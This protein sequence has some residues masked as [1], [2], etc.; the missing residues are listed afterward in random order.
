MNDSY[1]GKPVNE[2][3]LMEPLDERLI[4]TLKADSSTPKGE[5]INLIKE[6]ICRRGKKCRLCGKRCYR[7]D[8]IIDR[9][10]PISHGGKD[11]IENLQLL[12][13]KCSALKGNNTML[14][15]RKKLRAEKLN[16]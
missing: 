7:R 1:E 8:L 14:Q 4:Q 6:H 12:C 11:N 3:K 15:I 2:F 16:K 9:R 10:K 13:Q 5:I